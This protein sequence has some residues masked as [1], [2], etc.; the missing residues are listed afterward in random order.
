MKHIDEFNELDLNARP[1]S[2]RT[3][4][5]EFL[6]DALLTDMILCPLMFYGS[7]N[8]DDMEVNS[9]VRNRMFKSIFQGVDSRVRAL[10]A[11]QRSW[12]RC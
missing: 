7:A 5:K 10:A 11:R 2:A 12:R 3:V 9:P 1:Q 6:S 8:V 4:L